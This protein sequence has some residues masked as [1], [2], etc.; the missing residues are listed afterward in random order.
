MLLSQNYRTEIRTAVEVSV[1]ELPLDY[2]S[3]T[4]ATVHTYSAH[5]AGTDIITAM[6][7]AVV[8]LP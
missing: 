6:I 2:G 4:V 5:V 7:V 3:T 1:V 8:D